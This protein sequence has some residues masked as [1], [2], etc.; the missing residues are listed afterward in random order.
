MNA[1]Q[2][3]NVNW[4]GI[5]VMSSFI[6][7]GASTGWRGRRSPRSIRYLSSNLPSSLPRTLRTSIMS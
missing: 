1:G 4:F 3:A 7:E 2:R 5:E 6:L